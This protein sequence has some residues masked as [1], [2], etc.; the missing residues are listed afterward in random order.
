MRMSVR[1]VLAAALVGLT[2][3]AEETVCAPG[4]THLIFW[5]YGLF[6]TILAD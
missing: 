3:A 6:P 5:F 2:A 1:V 4:P